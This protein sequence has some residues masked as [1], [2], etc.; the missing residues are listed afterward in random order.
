MRVESLTAEQA[1]AVWKV[2]VEECGARDD[3]ETMEYQFKRYVMTPMGGFGHEFRFIGNLGF[4][5][6]FN[7]SGGGTW[8]SC[9]PEDSTPERDEAIRK[10]RRRIHAI[11]GETEEN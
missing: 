4:G 1:D 3:D 9:Y 6:K 2:L 8:V 5:G 10:A 11:T 7:V